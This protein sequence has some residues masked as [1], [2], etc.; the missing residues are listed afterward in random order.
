MT[1]RREASGVHLYRRLLGE[2]RP[3][4]RH[5]AGLTF[6]SLLA[7]VF[8]LLTPLP[9]KIAVDSVVGSTPLPAPLASLLGDHPTQTA[10]LAFAASLFVVIAVL[11]QAQEFGVLLLST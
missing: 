11:K 9:L 5:I 4:W 10:V 7:S 3:F 8:A 6:L 2:A 1:A